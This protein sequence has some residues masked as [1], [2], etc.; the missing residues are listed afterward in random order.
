[1]KRS[2]CGLHDIKKVQVLESN[3]PIMNKN[4]L[5][6]MQVVLCIYDPFIIFVFRAMLIAL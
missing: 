6:I 2:L 3:E 4:I 1:M 5:F